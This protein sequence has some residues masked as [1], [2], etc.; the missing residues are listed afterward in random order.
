MARADTLSADLLR[1][2]PLPV[3]GGDD[4]KTDRGSVHVVG[5]TVSTAGAVLLAGVAALRVGAGRLA[6]TTVEETAV[7]LSV[8][9]PEAMVVGEPSHHGVLRECRLE[10]QPDAVVIGPGMSEPGKVVRSVLDTCGDAAV[11]LDAGALDDLPDDL[12]AQCVLT[13]NA[14][15]LQSLGD[16]SDAA[17]LALSAA[18]A[19]GAV[20]AT[21]GW[22]AAPDGRLWRHDNGSVALG[23]SGSGDVLA[24]I[25]GGLLA[26]G[27]EPAQAACW[28]Q[29]L[30][31][32]AAAQLAPRHGR[33]GL[34]ARE[35]LDVLPGLVE[36]L[37]P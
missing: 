37:S 14:T 29:W 19:R 35:L 22:V 9:V 24:G 7:A 16:G 4:D 34:L 5:G 20:V 31:G 17:D 18:A 28:G 25:I 10:H 15:E 8:A 2:W 26:R 21:H 32:Q 11:V 1:S 33:V 3:L 6:I 13:P 30:H 23:T 27:A 12:P 36:D